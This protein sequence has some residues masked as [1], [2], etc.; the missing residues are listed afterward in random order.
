MHP[1]AASSPLSPASDQAPLSN[2]FLSCVINGLS[3][4][5][6][7]K[8]R[9]HRWVMLN[10]TFC[11]FIG[12]SRTELLGRTEYDFLP[13]EQ[14]Q[15]FWERDEQ[16]FITGTQSEWEEAFTD[17]R[18][19]THIISTK[20]SLIQNAHGEAF[21]VG[22]IRDITQRKQTEEE[23]RQSEANQRVLLS[24]LP[25]LILRMTGDGTYLDFIPT[26]TFHIFG[27]ADLVGTSIH[28][29]LPPDLVEQRL[30]YMRKALETGKLQVYE[31]DIQ[32]NGEIRTEEV[33]ITV[34][35][36]NEVLIIVRDMTERKQAELALERLKD[37][38]EAR[39]E[40]RTQALQESEARLRALVDNLPFGC[41]ACDTD[42]RHIMQNATSIK[43]WG[44]LIGKRP[45]DLDLPPEILTKWLANDARTL[46]GE[47]LHLEN[48]YEQNGETRIYQ[49]FWLQSRLRMGF[50]AYWE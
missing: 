41:W 2:D 17:Q 19:I 13:T 9:Q 11:T 38:L 48:E 27:N 42:S 5:I 25:D 45:Q 33:R 15:T 44:N 49:P 26:E 43:Q 16:V 22:T 28:G 32:V 8:D 7:V 10:D 4:P 40:E 39:V 23:L 30:A 1:F 36:D 37:E 24:A 14:A 31:Q 29:S 46:A 21:L 35:G 6:F 50:V 34:S 12:R 3:D 18:G 20:T 47:V